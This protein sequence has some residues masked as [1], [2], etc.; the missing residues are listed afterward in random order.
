[1]FWEKKT[2]KSKKP[3]PKPR[4]SGKRKP[5]NPKNLNLGVLGKENQ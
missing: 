1:V 4:C 3:K 2:N 5:I